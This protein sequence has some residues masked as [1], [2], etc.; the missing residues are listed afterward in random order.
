MEKKAKNNATT[1]S[2]VDRYD[3]LG[4][5]CSATDFTGL[6]PAGI[7]D[8]AQLEAYQALYPVNPPAAV[9]KPRSQTRGD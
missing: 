6:I 9:R 8:E 4:T 5:A 1:V 2:D 7:T 3:Y